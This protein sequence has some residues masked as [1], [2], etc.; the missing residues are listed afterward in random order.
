MSPI[1]FNVKTRAD[2][3]AAGQFSTAVP[4]FCCN[5]RYKVGNIILSHSGTHCSYC[6]LSYLKQCN[7][8]IERNEY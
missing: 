4:S 5:Y 7:V 3:Y 8:Y 6:V 2:M 1:W